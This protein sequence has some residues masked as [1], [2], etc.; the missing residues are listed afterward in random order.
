[1]PSPSLSRTLKS[2]SLP[3]PNDPTLWILLVVVGIALVVLSSPG[4]F[5]TPAWHLHPMRLYERFVGAVAP[6]QGYT[7]TMFGVDWCGHCKTAKPEFESLG[8]TMTIGGKDVALRFVNPE[9]SPDAAK[10]YEIGG[11]PTF[12]L[13]TPQGRT[14]YSGARNAAGFRSFLTQQLG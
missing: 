9:T 4:R 11:Y 2:L 6:G 1:M 10:G 5:W 12:Y 13:D 7:F 8:S 14:K 3:K